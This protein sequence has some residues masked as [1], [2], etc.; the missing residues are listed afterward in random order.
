MPLAPAHQPQA[1]ACIRAVGETWPHLPQ[2]ACFDTALPQDAGSAV[3]TLPAAARPHRRGAGALRL[4][5]AV[6]RSSRPKLPDRAGTG[7][8]SRARASLCAIRDGRSVATTMGFT[9]LDGLMMGTRS[10]AVDPGL[11]LHLIRER[12][13]SP[14]AVAELLTSGR[15]FSASPAS[16]TTCGSWR[17]A[18]RRE[19]VRP[20]T[21][22]LTGSCGGS[23]LELA[24]SRGLVGAGRTTRLQRI[25]EHAAQ[26]RVGVCRGLA[27]AG[28]SR[29]TTCQMPAARRGSRRPLGGHDPNRA[30][31]RR[32]A[33]DRPVDDR[34]A[35][36]DVSA[37]VA[38]QATARLPGQGAG[39]SSCR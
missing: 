37:P 36:P 15:A 33:R 14:D 12:G 26:V 22:S 39:R 1:L 16:A 23:G 13:L 38:E 29:S 31:E 19:R 34:S 3:P 7:R 28:A 30:R 8:P 35:R 25:G 11:V 21:C 6:L 20:W 24:R 4:P 32:G 9:T 18:M 5:R 27:F 17:R 2:V 10:G